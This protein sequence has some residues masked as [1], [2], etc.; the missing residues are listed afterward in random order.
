MWTVW[1]RTILSFIVW[2]CV[3]SSSTLEVLSKQFL[4]FFVWACC[5]MSF[6]WVWAWTDE[7][8]TIS[9]AWVNSFLPCF[10]WAEIETPTWH[11]PKGGFMMIRGLLITMF[12]SLRGQNWK[13]SGFA[14]WLRS[15]YLLPS[16]VITFKHGGKL[17]LSTSLKCYWKCKKML[18]HSISLST[19]FPEIKL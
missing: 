13:S 18:C 11:P 2:S 5:D 17:H 15:Q 10:V 7:E 19:K 12:Y 3:M 9:T 14:S 6:V 16:E 1:V 4:S 8:P